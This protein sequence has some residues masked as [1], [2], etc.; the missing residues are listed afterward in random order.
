M[1]ASHSR[2]FHRFFK[3]FRFGSF[4]LFFFSKFWPFVSLFLDDFHFILWI[5][6]HSEWSIHF[7]FYRKRFYLNI[8]WNPLNKKKTK[9]LYYFCF[10]QHFVAFY[11]FRL[12]KSF[13]FKCSNKSKTI[14]N[15]IFSRARNETH[16]TR[17]LCGPISKVE[18]AILKK[19][20]WPPSTVSYYNDLC[21]LVSVDMLTKSSEMHNRDRWLSITFVD[22]RATTNSHIRF[23]FHFVPN[24]NLEI[25]GTF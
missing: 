11:C 3:W 6:F 13:F 25:V 14:A 7:F 22:P 10:F 12:T 16:F 5:R 23:G 17:G 21:E 19:R 18:N 8:K 2:F 20:H 9:W 1:H 24:N 4:S 15:L